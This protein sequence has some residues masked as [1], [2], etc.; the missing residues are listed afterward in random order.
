MVKNLGFPVRPAQSPE[1]P[2]CMGLGG[3]VYMEGRTKAFVL[4]LHLHRNP[5]F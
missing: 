3:A 1:F 2:H 5:L 4:K